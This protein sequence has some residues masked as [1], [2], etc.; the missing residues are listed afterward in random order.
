MG[1]ILDFPVVA[2]RLRPEL[3]EKVHANNFN[4]LSYGNPQVGVER[5]ELYRR[6]YGLALRAAGYDGAIDYEY[7]TIDPRESWDDFDHGH[8]RD[9][10][11]AYPAIGKPVDTIQ[12][13]GWRE[14]V[15][16]IRYAT[17]LHNAIASAVAAGQH[18]ELAADSQLW[19]DGITGREDLDAV[20][21][22]MIRRIDALSGLE[23]GKGIETP[24]SVTT[25]G[26]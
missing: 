11:F 20:R 6:N 12:F 21:S 10:N 13:E 7:R 26:D 8:Y 23:D 18:V 14:G 3:A 24:C 9:H 1:D 19:L 25:Q 22:E 15:D 17:T 4:I 5:P 2:G 16:D